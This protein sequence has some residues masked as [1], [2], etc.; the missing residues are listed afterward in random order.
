MKEIIENYGM[1]ALTDR[2]GVPGGIPL[3]LFKEALEELPPHCIIT[4]IT[5]K[6]QDASFINL[7]SI[8]YYEEHEI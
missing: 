7:L 1:L 6:S 5:T 3:E 8:T 2:S 4:R